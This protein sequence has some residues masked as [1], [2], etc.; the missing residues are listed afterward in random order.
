MTGVHWTEKELADFE[1]RN[2]HAAVA[3]PKIDTNARLFAM[4]P[5]Q[6]GHFAL[7]RLPTGTMN[8]T[9]AAYADHLEQQRRRGEILWFKFEALKFRLADNTF[10]TPDFMVL[11]AHSFVEL[12]EVKGFMTDDA[13]VKIK[14]AASIYPFKFILVRKRKGGGWDL[15]DR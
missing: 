5:N 1:A 14:V 2:R 13:N 7:G 15:E 4:P 8:K 11:T 9:E 10:Y 3:A 6:A 12:H